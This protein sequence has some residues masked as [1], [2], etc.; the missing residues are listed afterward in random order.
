MR[1]RQLRG[2]VIKTRILE[3]EIRGGDGVREGG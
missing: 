1:L 2:I 3:F